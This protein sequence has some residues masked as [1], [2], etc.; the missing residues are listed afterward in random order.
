MAKAIGKPEIKNLLS[1][2]QTIETIIHSFRN[3]N[4]GDI[5]EI[6]QT[7]KPIACFI[8]CS[9]LIGQLGRHRY[10]TVHSADS[11]CFKAFVFNYFPHEYKPITKKL[12]K[13]LRSTLV[14]N[15]STEA[16]FSLGYEPN[17]EQYHLEF[18]TNGS[19]YLHIDSFINDVTFAFEQYAKELQTVPQ[20]RKI[21][22]EHFKLY[23]ILSMK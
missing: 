10:Y 15:Y 20:I 22:I 1:D 19:R 4:L 9:C 3:Y 17:T 21:A 7:G 6:R 13:S 5:K 12:Y 18:E 8:L 16:E 23:P 11:E 2:D 14:H